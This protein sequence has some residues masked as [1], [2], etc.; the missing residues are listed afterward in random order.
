MHK[1]STT[2]YRE[3]SIIPHVFK[4]GRVLLSIQYSATFL[5]QQG[6]A[7]FLKHSDQTIPWQ[8]KAG[9]FVEAKA[10]TPNSELIHSLDCKIQTPAKVF[11]RK[12][13][14]KRIIERSLFSIKKTISIHDKFSSCSLENTFALGGKTQT[15]KGYSF[16]HPLAPEGLGFCSSYHKQKYC[17]LPRL[18]KPDHLL[19]SSDFFIRKPEQKWMRLPHPAFWV[20]TEYAINDFFLLPAQLHFDNIN[21]S[22]FLLQNLDFKYPLFYIP[23]PNSQVW[24]ESNQFFTRQQANIQYIH[25]EKS[26]N[27]MHIYWALPCFFSSLEN[28]QKEN[29][30]FYCEVL[31]E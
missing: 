15:Q 20:P 26:K 16:S 30:S 17:E 21:F 7:L 28:W 5:L 31:H 10:Q 1:F 11:K 14:G 22:Q 29:P 9:I 3:S 25:V 2:H 23:I 8:P 18:E 19:T 12:V 4:D 6:K 27:Q 13:F 24:I